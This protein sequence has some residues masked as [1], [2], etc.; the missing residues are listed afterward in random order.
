MFNQVAPQGYVRRGE[1]RLYIAPEV[2]RSLSEPRGP[3]RA[4]NCFAN[5][6]AGAAALWA[7]FA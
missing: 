2:A 3:I 5:R 1:L 4:M 6:G 7:G